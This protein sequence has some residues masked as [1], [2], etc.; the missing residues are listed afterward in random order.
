MIEP[1]SPTRV[2]NFSLLRILFAISV[3][4]THSYDL[5][6]GNSFRHIFF[7]IFGTGSLSGLAVDGFF[8]LSGYLIVRSYL[9]SSPARYLAKRVL[10][11]YPGFIVAFIVSIILAQ[12]FSGHS[13]VLPVKNFLHN[14][15]RMFFLQTPG[16]IDPYP[17]SYSANANGSMWTIAYEFR[18][19]LAVMVL[20]LLGFLRRPRLVF[21]ISFSL[22]L[23]LFLF[24]E[25]VW[26]PTVE[27]SA[28]SMGAGR[29]MLERLQE[30]TLGV[31][32]QNL[33][34]LT[35]FFAGAMYFY[36]RDIIPFNRTNAAIAALML[37]ICLFFRNVA[38]PGFAGFGSY[39]IFWFA[40]H[41]H[42]LKISKLLNK[43]DISYGMY[44]YASPIQKVF[45]A[46]FPG[47]QHYQLFISGLLLSSIAGYLSWIFVEK[48]CLKLKYR[49]VIIRIT[50][51]VY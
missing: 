38:E 27:H 34:L 26:P 17:G 43:T 49:F 3:I 33:R 4:W 36:F 51:P 14:I 47:I 23:V 30:M 31:P 2:N 15:I 44:L 7:R 10:R 40:L 6:D 29:W 8:I 28:G 41:V 50:A 24:P 42:P 37:I 12:F 22:L 45:V 5:I 32:F 48:P 1:A 18:C 25:G 11:I 13:L 35:M 20:G 21:W 19:Y 46:Q 16:L 9:N 39:L